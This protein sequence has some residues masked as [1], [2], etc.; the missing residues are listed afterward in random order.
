MFFVLR[1]AN[2]NK[3]L[4]SYVKRKV[5]TAGQHFVVFMRLLT[6]I[7]CVSVVFSSCWILD[8]LWHSAQWRELVWFIIL[9]F[10]VG[11]WVVIG[12]T[13]MTNSFSPDFCC[14]SILCSDAACP[15][16]SAPRA[17]T[18][19]LFRRHDSSYA[20]VG[21]G[22]ARGFRNEFIVTKTVR[23]M[24]SV[25]SGMSRPSCRGQQGTLGRA[26]MVHGCN[27]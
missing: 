16:K 23:K 24:Q 12:H 3:R 17:E 20:S 25:D 15:N 4:C 22:K 1:C 14:I 19:A 9:T 6:H 11:F 21:D 18:D 13:L 10:F 8:F 2:M 26:C 7:S 5:W 27:S